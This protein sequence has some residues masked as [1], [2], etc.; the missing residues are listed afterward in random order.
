MNVRGGLG[1]DG[2]LGVG[3]KPVTSFG[4]IPALLSAEPAGPVAIRLLRDGAIL[5]IGVT[6]DEVIEDLPP[7]HPHP[8]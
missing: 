4:D 7:E 3:G 2:I 5:D 1:D 6:P 8:G